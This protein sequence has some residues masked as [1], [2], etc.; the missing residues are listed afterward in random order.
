MTRANGERAPL[1][2]R[3]GRLAAALLAVLMLAGCGQSD[4]DRSDLIDV[5]GVP[6]VAVRDGLGRIR[7]VDC[8][9]GDR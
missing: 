2:V 3:G 8:D 4:D 5:D 6:C 7:F 1:T 9:W